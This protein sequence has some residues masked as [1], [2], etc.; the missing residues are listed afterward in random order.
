M[1]GLG[2]GGRAEWPHSFCPVKDSHF[3]FY[4]LLF[5]GGMG[6][7]RDVFPG[8]KE[9]AQPWRKKAITATDIECITSLLRRTWDIS[10]HNA[11]LSR[12]ITNSANQG[13]LFHRELCNLYNLFRPPCTHRN[14]HGCHL[15]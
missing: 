3:G 6:R 12:S 7:G 10:V 13:D 8:Q 5:Y 2:A 1:S 9:Q 15:C 14:Q 4:K 11:L